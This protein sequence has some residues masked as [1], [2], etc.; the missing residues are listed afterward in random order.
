LLLRSCMVNFDE[1][2]AISGDRLACVYGSHV[3]YVIAQYGRVCAPLIR[4]T[5]ERYSMLLSGNEDTVE[6]VSGVGRFR[7]TGFGK[8]NQCPQILCKM[9]TFKIIWELEKHATVP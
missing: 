2:G 4:D 7:A 5:W 9:V 8:H 6:Y 3:K 1:L